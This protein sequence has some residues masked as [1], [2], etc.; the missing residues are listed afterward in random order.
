MEQVGGH[1]GDPLRDDRGGRHQPPGH[2][3]VEHEVGADPGGTQQVPVGHGVISWSKLT[4]TSPL[5]ATMA[6]DSCVG[7]VG[8]AQQRPGGQHLGLGAR[9]RP[10]G[11]LHGVGSQRR[12]R[13]GVDHVMEVPDPT[14]AWRPTRWP[15]PPGPVGA[16][17]SA[18]RGSP[19]LRSG[20]PA[21]ERHPRS[22]GRHRRRPAPT[23]DRHRGRP[24]RRDPRSTPSRCRR[25][26][27]PPPAAAARR[28]GAP[29][30]PFQRPHGSG[31]CSAPRA[32]AST[33]SKSRSYPAAINACNTVGSN[34]PPVA[35]AWSRASRT[36]RSNGDD[37]G[38]HRPAR[39]FTA[40]SSLSSRNREN[41][42]SS[43]SNTRPIAANASSKASSSG[44]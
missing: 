16:W 39:R 40:V 44:P 23:R 42:R 4:M 3:Q 36:T 29:A 34:S 27:G 25:G 11:G 17:P 41:R 31:G 37:T 6:Q 24:R 14:S 5:E 28:R 20:S 7:G 15:T 8:P 43:V 18:V 13:P 1:L 33:S 19:G 30:P 9:R 32:P 2:R 38:T 35:D 26:P 12:T 22:R 21:R 10:D